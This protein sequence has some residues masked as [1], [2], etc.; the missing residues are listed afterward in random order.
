[1]FVHAALPVTLE[2]QHNV[3]EADLLYFGCPPG[4]AFVINKALNIGRVEFQPG[5]VAVMTY[6]KPAETG[7]L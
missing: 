7:I 5:D 6:A 1:L 2:V 4:A 3:C